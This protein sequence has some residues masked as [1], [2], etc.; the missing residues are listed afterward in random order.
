MSPFLRWAHPC[1]QLFLECVRSALTWC[2]GLTTSHGG[3]DEASKQ[4][5]LLDKVISSQGGKVRG[6]LRIRLRFQFE[7]MNSGV[8][9]RA[10]F[11]LKRQKNNFRPRLTSR[12][13]GHREESP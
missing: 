6:K 7:K 4:P 12:L 11:F 8:G 13:E 3:Q 1:V 2:T 10:V 9:R 5:P